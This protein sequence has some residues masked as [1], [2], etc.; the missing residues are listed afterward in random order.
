MAEKDA[1]ASLAVSPA[2]LTLPATLVQLRV[3]L[4]AVNQVR[5]G[6]NSVAVTGTAT[7]LS[8]A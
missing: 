5:P 6:S 3:W 8:V 7:S 1:P 2:A 4:D